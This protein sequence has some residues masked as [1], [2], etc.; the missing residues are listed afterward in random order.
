MPTDAFGIMSHVVV[1][2]GRR[3]A[4]SHHH[5][6]WQ[7]ITIFCSP[8][9]QTKNEDWKWDREPGVRDLSL[10]LSFSLSLS[11][12]PIS[13]S[14]S[15]LYAASLLP[16]AIHV[17]EITANKKPATIVIR[18]LHPPRRVGSAENLLKTVSRETVAHAM[19]FV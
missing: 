15:L 18:F 10:S 19:R 6:I 5:D 3:R 9:R 16:T 7:S 11:L 1:V 14:L 12:L 4:V 8:L 13:H 2:R 17:S